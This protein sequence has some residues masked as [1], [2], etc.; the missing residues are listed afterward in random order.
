MNCFNIYLFIFIFFIKIYYL[1]NVYVN[2]NN[3]NDNS[4]ISTQFLRENLTKKESHVTQPV[5]S[6]ILLEN[7]F[8]NDVNS[9][10]RNIKTFHKSIEK[11]SPNS[12]LYVHEDLINFHNSQFVG[13]IEI[14]TP[15]QKFKVVFDTGSSN[16][17]V[18]S[19]KCVKGGCVPHKKYDPT[20]STT[21]KTNLKDGGQPLFTFIEY[22]TGT[23]VLE[24][25]YDDVGIQGLKI[26]KQDIGLVVEES[27]HPFFELPFDGIVGLGFPDPDFRQQNR[28]AT[29]LIETIKEQNLLRRNIFSF[30]VPKDLGKPASIS[31][32]RANEKYVVAGKKVEWIPVISIYYW[33]VNISDIL[34]FD[35]SLGFCNQKKCRAAIDTGSSLITGPSTIMQPIIEKLHLDTNCSNKHILPNI[36]FV[37]K[38]V[39]G[40]NV[41]LELTPDDY[42]IEE[43]DE[44]QKVIECVIGFMPLDVPAPRGPIFIFGNSFIRKYYTIFDNDHKIVG[45]VEANH[46]F[47]NDN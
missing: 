15:P 6:E 40:K 2:A 20:K 25:G 16:L 5:F 1:V 21:F 17:W 22:G 42:V 43:L 12:L 11:N 41:T 45:V 27:L 29:P 10:I 36:S 13:E 46:K 26:P 3:E 24:H 44:K 31:F 30:Y 9:F 8:K 18:P 37:L 34:I 47:L 7:R 38:N 4:R 33:E 14:G 23:C 32:G 28:D 35:R 39:E 19:Q